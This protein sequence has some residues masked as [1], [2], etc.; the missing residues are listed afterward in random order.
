[1]CCMNGAFL[2]TYLLDP[3]LFFVLCV[4]WVQ[5]DYAASSRPFMPNAS[6]NLGAFGVVNSIIL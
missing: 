1:M 5:W 4:D 2:H 6:M 3:C